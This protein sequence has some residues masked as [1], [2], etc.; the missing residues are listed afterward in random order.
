MEF[1]VGTALGAAGLLFGFK[2]ALDGYNA[3][4]DLFLE[5][6][7]LH[8]LA[9]RYRFE[10]FKF[11]QL[12]RYCKVDEPDGACILL[13]RPRRDQE[14]FLS[15][16]NEVQRRQQ[17]AAS[18]F[19]DK[20]NLGEEQPGTPAATTGDG[21]VAPESKS[22]WVA[23]LKEQKTLK[24]NSFRS[25]LRWCLSHKEEFQKLVEQLAQLNN[26]LWDLAKAEEDEA[27]RVVAGVLKE[28]DDFWVRVRPKELNEAQIATTVL[29]GLERFLPSIVKSSINI[30]QLIDQVIVQVKEGI[31]KDKSNLASDDDGSEKRTPSSIVKLLARAKA[32]Q[33]EK[34]EEAAKR[35]T[36][37]N[38]AELESFEVHDHADV[39]QAKS[40]Y[41]GEY[42]KKGKT[43]T[44]VLVEWKVV[45]AG[46]PAQ[47]EILTRIEALG[48][49]LC[50]AGAAADFC[51]F[52]SLGLYRDRS[53]EES[54]DGSAA[55]LHHSRPPLGDRLALAYRLAS[56]VSLLHVSDWLHKS[57]RSSNV[58]FGPG[59]WPSSAAA[60]GSS[61]SSSSSPS[62]DVTSP[63]ICGFQYSRPSD[64]NSLEAGEWGGDGGTG[65]EGGLDYYRHPSVAQS[66]WTKVA[67]IYSLGVVLLE[68][69]HWRPLF[70][71][72][73][74]RKATTLTKVHWDVMKEVEGTKAM[75]LRGLVGSVFVDSIRCCLLAVSGRSLGVE[76]GTSAVEAKR[77]N[78]A[79]VR[80]V[81]EPI[82]ACKA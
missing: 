18:K 4:S 22:S 33:A 26:D 5:D 13:Q 37:I 27:A 19:L 52:E 48:T 78:D 71:S 30:Q 38:T 63:Y 35:V 42:Q 58:L 77:L 2:G 11:E 56:A 47:A 59:T 66:G 72:S 54:T 75:Q 20:Y 79:F 45:T 55:K 61:P 6:T 73:Q 74:L 9:L 24:P 57:M 67:E 53:H 64:D 70:S 40:R 43:K 76:T 51:L 17:F 28:L 12:G 82:A 34:V 3:L 36:Y 44:P 10:A 50:S 14:V 8:Y 81:L 21:L 80:L 41:M 62:S 25:R 31:A 23:M 69:A 49:L 65:N 1:A 32:I 29:D 68:V 16:L 60:W 39:S 7:G 46:N 15:H